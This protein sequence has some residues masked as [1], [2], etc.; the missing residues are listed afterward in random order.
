MKLRILAAAL[1]LTAQATAQL[2]WFQH[3]SLGV[4]GST[5][6]RV[7]ATAQGLLAVAGS[8]SATFPLAL[9]AYR[10]QTPGYWLPVGSTAF[11]PGHVL[12]Q[13]VHDRGRGVTIVRMKRI[14]QVVTNLT[15]AWNGTA[16]SVVSPT[17]IGGVTPIIG[18]APPSC[19][20]I[21]YDEVT[22]LVFVITN[23]ETYQLDAVG[24][25]RQNVAGIQPSVAM[26][27]GTFAYNPLRMTMVLLS[28]NTMWEFDA[29]YYTWTWFANAPISQFDDDLIWDPS[30]Q[31]LHTGS[32]EYNGS[33]WST[34]ANGPSSV[35][36]DT[37]S[38]QMVG[39]NGNSFVYGTRT[40]AYSITPFGT[41]C[42][43]SLGLPQLVVPREAVLA[44]IGG[45]AV[46]ELNN[47]PQVPAA[48]P[49]L[50]IGFSNTTFGG[51]L[52]PYNLA[53]YGFNGCY[54]N[55][56]PDWFSLGIGGLFGNGRWYF[57]APL[58]NPAYLGMHFY[59]QGMV[60][61]MF[62]GISMSVGMDCMIGVG[63]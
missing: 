51:G 52:L 24:W 30:V 28:F 4:H 22:Q 45:N 60:S 50:A 29:Q 34:V 39:Y 13:V 32:F 40:P 57:T 7:V 42:P 48:I 37:V 58:Y 59:V 54:L 26:N 47:I 12:A 27:R 55:V 10:W 41:G 38:Q 25:S 49:Y 19:W 3:S 62:G 17:L 46:I 53:P 8:D 43:S 1:F 35:A 15:Y 56:S 31:K 20:P 44:G 18:Q 63:N 23:G 16:W 11:P 5:P 61:H 6:V 2:G 14:D 9:T 33:T 21:A 36:F